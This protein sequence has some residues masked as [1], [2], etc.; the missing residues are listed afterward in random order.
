MVAT[1][2][3]PTQIFPLTN[4]NGSQPIQFLSVQNHRQ[5]VSKVDVRLFAIGIYL[6]TR[7]NISSSPMKFDLEKQVENCYFLGFWLIVE[8]LIEK[9]VSKK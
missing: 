7:P 4:T 3:S 1:G 6:N 5:T 9:K 2:Y 8:E